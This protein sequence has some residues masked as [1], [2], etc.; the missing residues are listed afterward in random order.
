M[1]GRAV[2]GLVP[3]L[4]LATT[5]LAYCLIDLIRRPNPKHLPRWVWA[6]ICCASIPLGGIVYLLVGRAN[7]GPDD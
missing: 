1:N 2:L 6:L 3:L 4:A 5:F 7:E